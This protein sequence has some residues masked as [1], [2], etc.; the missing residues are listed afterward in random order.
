[1]Q[2][3]ALMGSDLPALPMGGATE[4]RG[5]TADSRAVKPGF[6]FAALPGT[7]VDG[8]RFIPQAL[9]Q[10]AVALLV[11]QDAGIEAR[12][13]VIAVRN[14]RRR[15]ALMAARFFGKQ[16]GIVA[17][18]TGTNGKT[19]V[20]T[21]V[22]Q[23]WAALGI[24][25]ASLG[26]LGI[27]TAG[28]ARELGFTTPDPVALQAE[29]AVL[30]DEGVT[31]LAM[32]ASSHGLAQY[33]LDGVKLAAAGFTNITR[34]HMDY[35]TSFDDYLYAKLRLFGEVMGPGGV[36][37]INAD[38]AQAAEF[39][40]LCWAR[41][42]RIVSV[43]RKG[44]GICLIA[45]RPTPRGQAL[46]LVHG[47]ANY[48]VQLPLVGAFQ[49]SNALVA[50]GLVIG[51]GGAAS[52]VFEALANLKGAR[53]RMEEAAHLP[54]GASVY[55][56][57]AHTPDALENML[58]A[59]RPH[60]TGKLAV[61]FG[62]GGDRDAGKRPQMGE[63]A[64]RLADTVYVTDDNPRSEEAAVIR[65]AI[66]K[67]CPGAT[68]IGDRAAAIETAMRAL[69]SGDVLVVAG[70]GHETGQTV[71]DKVIPFSDHDAVATATKKIGGGA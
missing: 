68:E 57:Y 62:C 48:E 31:H 26:T 3:A 70:K 46:E 61:V 13:P 56:D 34:D 5:L 52:R 43:G 11:P 9:A 35:H 69:Q 45:V 71:G 16:P 21:F 58:E 4:I 40:A 2:L 7:K 20:A 53:G 18:V 23:I 65:A 64:A 50:A 54:S 42:H 63:I 28:A 51:C 29:L 27:E 41:G 17:A 36:A 39:E 19:S 60:A 14:P 24:E 59:M 55:I 10:G 25:A 1:M 49:A 33:R 38:S 47:G 12:V 6:L 67:A 44:R 32:E 66:L 30:A 15:L 22:R 8:S 37:V